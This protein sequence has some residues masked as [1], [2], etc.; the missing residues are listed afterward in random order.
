[1]LSFFPRGVLDEIL[2]LI[3]SISEGFPSFSLRK[4]CPFIL[5]FQGRDD[6]S[7]FCH[8]MPF[9]LYSIPHSCGPNRHVCCQFDFNRGMCFKG[10]E[11]LEA[12][13]VTDSNVASL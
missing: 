11:K 9:L 6:K 12:M 5:S 8:M 7:I 2:N 3:E 4:V 1:M 10:K 13:K